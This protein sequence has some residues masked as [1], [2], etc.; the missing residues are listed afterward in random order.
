MQLS[1][2]E[3]VSFSA[4]RAH[5]Y[6]QN[7]PICEQSYTTRF[8]SHATICIV[9]KQHPVNESRYNKKSAW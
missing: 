1:P 5:E 8:A 9:L 4:W 7:T 6:Q 2:T 3:Y